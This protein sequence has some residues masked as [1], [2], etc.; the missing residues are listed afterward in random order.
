MK[1]RTLLQGA[2]AAAGAG[3]VGVIAQPSKAGAAPAEQSSYLVGTGIYDI[4]GAVAET[5]AFGYASGQEITGFHSRLYARAFIVVDQES[6]NRVAYVSCDMGAIFQSVKIG[7]V[8][9]LRDTFADLY[10]D[11]N[12]I[13]TATHT[14]SGNAGFSW[15]KL[16]QI[17]GNDKSGYGWD[18]ANYD[19][20]VSGIVTAIARADFNLE[21]GTIRLATTEVTGITKS[22]ADYPYTLNPDALA[23]QGNVNTTMVQLNFVSANGV[24][25]GVLNWFAIHPTAFPMH[26]RY[27][28]GDSKGY[29]QWLF[30]Q[31]MGTDVNQLKTFVAAFANTDA[32]DVVSEQGNS[33][34]SPG[35][36]GSPDDFVNVQIDGVRQYE[37]ALALWGNGVLVS[38]PIDYRSHWIDLG[39]YIVS[40]T[41]TGGAG[42]RPLAVPGRGW[43][44]AAGGPNGP[45]GI[46]GIY[47]GMTAGTF[48]IGD[49]INQVDT[50]VLAGL[51]RMALSAVSTIGGGGIDPLQGEKPVLLPDG[52]W[53]WA[54]LTTQVQ[55]MRIGNLAIVAVPGEITTMSGRRIRQLVLDR[56]ASVGVSDVVLACYAND[57]QG[58]TATP[59]EYRAQYYEGASTEYGPYQLPAFLQEFDLLAGALASGS[60]VAQDVQPADRS[61]SVPPSRPGVLFD[62]V[63]PRQRFGQVLAQP[64]GAYRRGE[65]A[66]AVY[67]SGHPKNDFRTMG[68]FLEVQRLV[69][70]AWVTY[71]SDRDWDTTYAWRR[72][73]AAY[74]RVTI[75]WR[76]AADTPAGSYR[77][78]HNGEWK[79]GVRVI[80]AYTGASQPFTVS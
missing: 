68:T 18:Q 62:D 55:I 21:P 52:K 75:S 70:G 25:L 4:T 10:H 36:Q 27:L 3:S 15:D 19:T 59:E 77:L 33:Q 17:A 39:D 53:G 23:Y 73:G 71:R 7:V 41:Y 48:N 60:I 57:Y 79:N 63:P 80:T 12:V 51:T 40:G 65:V 67:R 37:P 78:V 29:A 2:I 6:G 26:G 9:Q 30:E 50:S 45:S 38:G 20:V 44:F 28:N 49:T 13:L 43:S 42:D 14:H 56:L 66:S 31:Q 76:I 34:S 11:E 64:A 47:P 69:D 35:Y 58:Y 1:R 54:P 74:S 5:G 72:E 16:Y 61:G 46:P 32:G 8:K 22:R 24:A